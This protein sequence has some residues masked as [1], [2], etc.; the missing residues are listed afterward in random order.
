VVD[1]SYLRFLN[2]FVKLKEL[3]EALAFAAI[4]F[5]VTNLELTLP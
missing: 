1:F 4:E 2:D 3:L 5:A